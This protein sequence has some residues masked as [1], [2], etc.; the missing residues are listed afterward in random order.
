MGVGK[1][2]SDLYQKIKHHTFFSLLFLLLSVDFFHIQ[3]RKIVD[4]P[5]F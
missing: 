2:E 1:V 3:K 4:N 5:M